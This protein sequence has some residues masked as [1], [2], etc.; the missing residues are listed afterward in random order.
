MN[1][2]TLDDVVRGLAAWEARFR[3]QQDRRCI[4]LT[5]YGIVSAEMRDRVQ[6]R[7]FAD[8]DWVHRYAV[9]FANLYRH[10][11]EEYEAGRRAN[12]PKAWR[13][14]FDAAKQ[15][16]GLVLQ[17]MFLGVNAHVNNDL[18]FALTAVSIEPDREARH[19][20]HAAVNEVLGSV[21]E[22]AT[23][24]LA[25]LYAPGLTAMDDC[26]GQ[27]DEMLSLFSLQVARDSAWESAL[28]LANARN[29]AERVLASTL[30]GS[31]AAV[32]ARLLLAPSLN[33]AAVAACSRLEQGTAWLTMTR[34][35]T[36]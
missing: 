32:L 15:G 25:A 35:L 2:Q 3:D 26:A 23:A 20:D 14:C 24:R 7:A 27:L 28:S 21:T 29:A 30:I 11:L 9:A 1:Y 33:P 13:L 31:R 22:R 34:S 36:G 18:P 8:P 12:V 10:A 4:F 19:R 17:D 16:R 6:R 5:L